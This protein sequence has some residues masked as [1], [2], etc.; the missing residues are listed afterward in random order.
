MTKIYKIVSNKPDNVLEI[1][2]D[3]SNLCNFKCQ[4]CF[5]GS[6]FGTHKNPNNLN[7]IISNFRH[8]MD[9]YSKKLSKTKFHFVVAGGEPT[10]WKDL[11]SF[12]REIKKEHNIYFSL[13]SNGSRT[14]RWW[15]EYSHLIDNAHLTHHVAQGDVDHIIKVADILYQSGA[16]TTVK[17]LMDPLKWDRSIFD[18]E[19][20]KSSSKH[21]WFIS[22][23]KIIEDTNTISINYTDDQLLYIKKELKRIPSLFW[24]WKNRSLIKEDMRLWDST[25]YLKNG[26][27]KNARPGMYIND[28]L[29]SF[30][31][32]SCSIGLERIYVSWAGDISGSCRVKLYGLDYY[33]NILETE[34]RDKFSLIPNNTICPFNSCNCMPETHISKEI[35]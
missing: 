18:I 2:W 8:L 6:N 1:A 21:P 13:I 25:A 30:K 7:L 23:A 32:W 34:F 33:S 19:Y 15:E 17:V 24:F 12:I 11:G 5:Y 20:M 4:Y 28:S 10:L 29:N 16:K 9:Q 14:L 27:T 31:G 35:I 26:K 22:A 3:P